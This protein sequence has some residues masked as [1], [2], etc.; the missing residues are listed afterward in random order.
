MFRT[1]K[2]ITVNQC[3]SIDEIFDEIGKLK[4]INYQVKDANTFNNIFNVI[5]FFYIIK[6]L[7]IQKDK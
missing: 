3:G 5:S 6:L 4:Y 1:L 7:L 2:S